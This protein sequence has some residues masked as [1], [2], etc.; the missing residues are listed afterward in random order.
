MRALIQEKNAFPGTEAYCI[1]IELKVQ[2]I[3]VTSV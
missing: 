3:E 1:Q 2:S